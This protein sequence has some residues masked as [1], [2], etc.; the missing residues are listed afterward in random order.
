[1]FTFARLLELL[2]KNPFSAPKRPRLERHNARP[3]SAD[4]LEKLESRAKQSQAQCELF[5][6]TNEW[7]PFWLLRYTGLRP[8][9]AISLQGREVDFSAGKIVHVCHKNHKKVNIPLFP[10]DE[11][12]PALELEYQRRK[13]LPNEPVLLNLNTGRPFKYWALRDL[14]VKLGRLA[15][16]PGANPYRLRGTFAVDMYLRTNSAFYVARYLGDTIRMVEQH[17]LPFVE[18]LQ[19]HGRLIARRGAGLRQFV[20]PPSQQ[21]RTRPYLTEKQ[22]A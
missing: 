6:S 2:E 19:E 3:F 12:L 15:G 20:T 4:E 17:Y 14:V 21:K 13:P 9:D 7:L 10:E 8:N 18:E 1:V 11:L 16:V 5:P 22:S